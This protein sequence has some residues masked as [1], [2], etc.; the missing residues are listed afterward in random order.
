MRRCIGKAT[1][2]AFGFGM[3]AGLVLPPT[4]VTV[5]A[6]VLLILTLILTRCCK[7]F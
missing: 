6:V 2:L 1:V 3:F 5:I 7:F 4:W